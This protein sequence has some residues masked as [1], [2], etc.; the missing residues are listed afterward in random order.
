MPIDRYIRRIVLLALALGIVVELGVDRHVLGINVPIV[1]AGSLL[2]AW[3]VRPKGRRIDSL[4]LWLAPAALLFAAFVAVRADSALIT[5]DLAATLV[6][7]GASIAAL[8]GA[9]VTRRTLGAGLVLAAHVAAA[10]GVGAVAVA[11]RVRGIWRPGAATAVFARYGAVARG[12][13]IGI[14]LL[15]V[16][17]VLFA[18]AD[19]IFES[20]ANRVFDIQLDPGDVPARVFVVVATAWFAAGLLWLVAAGDAALEARSLGA[21]ANAPTIPLP[22]LGSTEALT[23]LVA[24]DVLFGAFVVLQVAYLFGGA[25]TIAASGVTY[26]N[27]ARRGFFEL[28]AVVFL[29]GALIGGF[30]AVVAIR[31]RPYVVAMLGL[32]ALTAVVLAS[33]F[34]RLRLYQDAYGWTELRFYVLASIGFLAVSLAAAAWFVARN[35]SRWLPHAVSA[36]GVA[37]LIGINAV[38]PQAYVTAR[39]LERAIDP[40]VVPGGVR[41]PVD[42]EYLATLQADAVPELV[43]ALPRLSEVSRAQVLVTL[44]QFGERLDEEAPASDIPGWNLSREL[45]RRALATLPTR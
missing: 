33:S 11:E 27:Y 22:R 25:D 34:L 14:P 8:A 18:A 42:T 6:L 4:D 43:D 10:A 23:V 44:R 31:T 1:V 19:P 3:L 12:L 16:F 45:A 41:V 32:I 26:A 39:N 7:A 35:G 36:A 29:V 40:S 9:A 20:I 37:V 28:L 17:G 5:I 24:L 2:A 30:E 15:I 13:L 21:A 38:G